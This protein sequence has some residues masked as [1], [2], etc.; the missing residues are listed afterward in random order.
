MGSLLII[1]SVLRQFII[2]LIFFFFVSFTINR[3]IVQKSTLPIYHNEVTANWADSILS[4][5]TLDQK[6]AQLF[7]VQ[8]NGKNLDENYYNKVDSLILKHEIGGL[9]FFQSGPSQLKSLLSRYNK[10]SPIGLL[11]GIDAEWGV[12]MR[13]DSVQT[14]PW[15]MTLGAIQ[16][17]DLL[18]QFGSHVAK[19]CQELG[20]HMN[21]APVL[22]INNNPNNPIIDRRSFGEDRYLVASKGI[23]YMQGLHDHNIL[24]CAKHFPGHGDTDVDSHLS[25][26]VIRHNRDR[27]DSLELFP[28][29]K[30]IDNRLGSIMVAHINLPTIDTLNVPSSFSKKLIMDILKDDMK[31]NGL[32]VSDAL[33]MH[34]L[35]DFSK[36]GERELNAFLAGNDI[37]LFPTNVPMAIS[38]IKS[39]V[40][41]SPLLYQ[42]LDNS[43]RQILMLKRWAFLASQKNVI[44]NTDLQNNS[45]KLLNRQL[46]KNAITLLQNN[47]A[48]PIQT[49]DSVKI[50]C[51]IMGSDSGD[52][53]YDR[54]NSYIPVSKYNYYSESDSGLLIDKLNHYDIII[55]SLHY[56]NNNF[57]EKHHLKFNDSIFLNKLINANNVILNI[58]GH[59][60]LLNSI[61]TS[62]AQ[63]VVLSYQNSY[64]FQDLSAQLHFGSIEVKGKLPISL[65]QF[66]IGDGL[67]LDKSRN[68]QFSL[69]VELGMDVDSLN[70]IDTLVNNAISNGIMP[71]CQIVVSRHGEIFYQKSFGYHTYDSIQLV[72]DDHL[73][74]VASITKIASAA[75]LIM[76]LYDQKSFNL[77][78]KLKHYSNL[79]KNTNKGNLKMIDILTHQAK[80]F[81]WIPFYKNTLNEFGELRDDLYTKDYTSTY[82]LLV[83]KNIFIKKS[84]TD[85]IIDDIINSELLET[86]EYRYSDLGFYLLQPILEKKIRSS[87]PNFLYKNFYYPMGVYRITYHPLEKF[88]KSK[89]VPTE[90]DVYFRKQLI[91]GYVHDQGAALFG[92]VALHAG[93]FANAID[94][95]KLMQFY[96]DGG[97]CGNKYLLNEKTIS[98]FTN[99]PFSHIKNRRGIIF[100]KPSIDPEEDGPTCDSISLE[101][102][103]HSGWTGTITWA[104]PKED[105]VFVFLSNGR[106]FPDGNNLRLVKENI[107][108]DIQK[109]IYNSIIN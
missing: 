72:R 85:T 103:G 37:L 23:L 30:L 82:S 3:D 93:L 17:D 106:A 15:M 81:P 77:N 5:L 19:Q 86:K 71:G 1:N 21:F 80:L 44:N 53:F 63:A 40:K 12:A 34:A 60:R 45:S 48:L 66:S 50:A 28:F 33:N 108:T 75:P 13:L 74:D 56:P 89:I 105:I 51:L 96:L 46:S 55:V 11:A 35:S 38:L 18:Y 95:M 94:L 39:K 26:P 6:I 69:P 62:N 14:F 57:W 7:M 29:K 65:N 32:V 98:K 10:I 27:L 36:P 61:N 31:F 58:F 78:K 109:I 102:F 9:I 87:I 24:A 73:Y 91:Q 79:F 16:D 64:D 101:S 20:L 76:Y 25:L 47:Q 59:P 100:D 22:D 99:S 70:E 90:N 104:D 43:C 97:K 49:N 2:V 41:N 54:L 83:A 92:G 84:F 107:R 42:Q 88:P 68:L 8:A 52:V 67:F 4:T